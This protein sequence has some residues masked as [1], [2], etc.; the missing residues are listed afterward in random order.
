MYYHSQ[1]LRKADGGLIHWRCWW[2]PWGSMSGT[3]FTFYI[4]FPSRFWHFKIDLCENGW[5]EEAL[6]ISISL[7]GLYL[8][9]GVDWSPL[10]KVLEKITKRKGQKYTNGRTIGFSIHSGKL[11]IDLWNDP[12]ESRSRDPKWWHFTFDPMELLFGKREYSEVVLDEGETAIDMPEGVYK[13]T[14]KKFV[15]TW[16]RP[17]FPFVQSLHRMSFDIPVGIPHEGKG[18]NSWDIGMDATFGSTFPI[19]ETDSM[20]EITNRFAIAR[21]QE[22]QK[23]GSLSSP[24]YA[25]WK[26]EREIRLENERQ[27][28]KN[29]EDILNVAGV[30]D[31]LKGSP[32]NSSASEAKMVRGFGEVKERENA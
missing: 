9:F 27:M 11:W 31:E 22:R 16:K 3:E 15:S 19:Q 26:L 1:N 18:E 12:M 4:N 32:V 2:K 24:D 10:Y 28:G 14:Y 23:Y 21:L 7:F 6:G 30:P 20:R 8:S 5:Q 25:K 29:D 13:A 17:R